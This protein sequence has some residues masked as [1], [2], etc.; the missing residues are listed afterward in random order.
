MQSWKKGAKDVAN[1]SNK[2]SLAQRFVG[3]K[4]TVNEINDW[5]KIKLFFKIIIKYN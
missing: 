5:V 1:V 3:V 4:E 2:M